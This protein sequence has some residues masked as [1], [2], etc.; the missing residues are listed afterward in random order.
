MKCKFDSTG[1]NSFLKQLFV[2]SAVFSLSFCFALLGRDEFTAWFVVSAII[3]ILSLTGLAALF[4]LGGDGSGTISAFEDEAFIS[5]NSMLLKLSD[6]HIGY[7][8]IERAEYQ[9]KDV[10]SRISFWY[11]EFILTIRRKS[12]G[13]IKIAV[14]LYIEEKMPLESP[15]EYKKYIDEQPI[16][17]IFKY[18]NERLENIG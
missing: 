16:M 3:L 7:D 2:L 5:R 9:I 17:K 6:I 12:G 8:D 14:N 18:I 10:R 15:K 13:E 1:K 11:Y 4:L